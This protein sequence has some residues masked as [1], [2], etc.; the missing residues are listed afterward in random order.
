MFLTEAQAA[1]TAGSR[2]ACATLLKMEFT[3]STQY[4]WDGI[5]YLQA[6][7]HSWL[8]FGKMGS[9]SGLEQAVRGT[10]PQAAFRLSGVDPEFINYAANSETEVKGRPVTVFTQF[11]NADGPHPTSLDSPVALWVGIMDIMKFSATGPRDRAISVTA[12]SA[13]VDR[14]RSPYSYYTDVDQK[15]RFHGDRGLEF[16]A[17]LRAK[18][19]NWLRG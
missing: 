13:F 17:A 8:G 6:D 3:S 15:A 2:V 5:G 10:A 9:I 4:L 14:I 18:T 7:G 19:V 11:L 1:M 16:A 12:E